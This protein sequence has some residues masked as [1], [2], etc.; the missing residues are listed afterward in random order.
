MA[1]R[2]GQVVWLVPARAVSYDRRSRLTLRW[3]RYR[4]EAAMRHFLAAWSA[5]AVLSG[6]PAAAAAGDLPD[7]AARGT[8]RVVV[9]AGEQPEMFSLAR[10]GP[11]GFEREMLEGF[12]SLHRLK[13]A[14]IPVRRREERVPSLLRG[15]GDVIVGLVDTPPR[16]KL[17]DFTR[18]VLPTHHVV[19]TCPPNRVVNGLEELGARRVG[20]VAGASSAQAVVDAGLPPAKTEG[21]ADLASAV[22][23]LRVGKVTAAVMSVYNFVLMARRH[24]GL[25]AGMT[26]GAPG[27]TAW[28]VRKEDAQ[29]RRALD[30]YLDN[31][32]KT[33]S[34]GRLV[35]KYFGEQALQVLGRAKAQ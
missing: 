1:A 18:E 11:P 5:A 27:R 8:L 13:L 10:G 26:L 28:G 16:R 20:F 6:V 23:A 17:I 33:P 2:R 29:L 35:V 12:A 4:G 34:W 9:G 21:F 25:Q 14:L 30:D 3:A 22:D 24:P 15:D 7:I 31:V 32:R 19:V